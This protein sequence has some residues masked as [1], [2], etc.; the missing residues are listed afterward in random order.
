MDEDF[1]IIFA[2]VLG[3]PKNEITLT[4][5]PKICSSWDS[6]ATLNLIEELENYYIRKFTLD[7]LAQLSSVESFWK[8][9]SIKE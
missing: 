7:E 8:L 6:L 3:V 4:L 2:N 1:I 5:S 9:V